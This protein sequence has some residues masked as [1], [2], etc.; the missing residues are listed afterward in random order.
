MEWLIGLTCLASPV[1]VFAAGF[2]LGRYSAKY[3]F[4]VEQVS[5]ED[6]AAPVM[7]RGRQER[8]TS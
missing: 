8:W 2:A 6:A 4:R 7:M 3:R 5:H 1:A